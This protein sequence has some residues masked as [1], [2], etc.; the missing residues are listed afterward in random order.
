MLSDE[1][2]KGGE[3]ISRGKKNGLQIIV[4][5]KTYKENVWKN[6]ISGLRIFPFLVLF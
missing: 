2:K 1:V 6:I 3:R 5:Y 4:I